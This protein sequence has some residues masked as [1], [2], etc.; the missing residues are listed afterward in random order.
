MLGVVNGLVH[1]VKLVQQNYNPAGLLVL[2]L[3]LLL[4]SLSIGASVARL[5]TSSKV[6]QRGD[7][8]VVPIMVIAIALPVVA[9]GLVWWVLL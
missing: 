8:L 4:A 7:G 6:T 2:W 1:T 5:L 3:A 9:G